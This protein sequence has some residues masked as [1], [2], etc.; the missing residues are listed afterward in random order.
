MQLE[1]NSGTTFEELFNPESEKPMSENINKG[2]QLK[3][4]ISLMEMFKDIL[5]DKFQH[6]DES[7]MGG[8]E[9]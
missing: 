3:F 1:F 4:E 8:K 2:M 5:L 7:I 6:F 9:G